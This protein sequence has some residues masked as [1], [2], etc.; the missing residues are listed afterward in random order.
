MDIG[1]IL[2]VFLAH[3]ARYM[4]QCGCCICIK[5]SIIQLQ[6]NKKS[7]SASA[8]I[9]IH[10]S[11]FHAFSIHDMKNFTLFYVNIEY[12]CYKC[13]CM[14]SKMDLLKSLSSVNCAQIL[15]HNML[16]CL[17]IFVEIV[18]V[19]GPVILYVFASF[20]ISIRLERLQVQV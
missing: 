10:H 19:V 4:M 12:K 6:T 7:I 5:A 8:R 1:L 14:W 2:F 15:L 17:L 20:N 13:V 16:H 11:K 9:C 18:S 3:L